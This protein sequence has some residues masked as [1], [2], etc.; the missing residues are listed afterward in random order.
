MMHGQQNVKT[1]T[2]VASMYKKNMYQFTCTEQK[3][4]AH[5]ISEVY[6]SLQKCGP[7]GGDL[8]HVILLAPRILKLS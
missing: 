5:G 7:S 3:A 6:K 1:I 4:H 8:L 2:A